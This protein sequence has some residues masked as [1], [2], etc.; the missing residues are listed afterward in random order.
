MVGGHQQ[1]HR[2]LKNVQQAAS[3]HPSHLQPPALCCCLRH[4]AGS[5][6]MDINPDLRP[7][8]LG[9]LFCAAVQYGLGDLTDGGP[10]PKGRYNGG[11]EPYNEAW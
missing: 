6:F 5:L 4:G 11:H 1:Q 9:L 7:C 3:C 2:N 8:V 10:T